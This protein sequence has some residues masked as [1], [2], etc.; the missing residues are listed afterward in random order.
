MA[1]EMIT[2]QQITGGETITVETGPTACMG[3]HPDRRLYVDSLEIA[4]ET[5]DKNLVAI[6]GGDDVTKADSAT[7]AASVIHV[8]IHPGSI[9]PTIE[10]TFG[11]LISSSVRTKLQEKVSNVS[12]ASANDITIKLG[13]TN[14]KQ[15]YKTDDKWGIMIDLSNLEL[16]PVSAE[17]FSISIQPTE[18][19]GVAKNGMKY[20]IITIN[21][22]TTDK[23]SLPVCSAASTDKGVSKIGYI[24]T[25]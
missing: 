14:K 24:A 16:Y 2:R 13:N 15:E 6:E 22:L 21:G 11:A 23:G 19:M 9:N 17:S 25:S 7:A 18:L 10:I 5:I 12:T 20:H 8:S 1:Q 3:S 4:G